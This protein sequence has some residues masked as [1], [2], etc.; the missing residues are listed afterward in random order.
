MAHQYVKGQPF[1]HHSC[2]QPRAQGIEPA[3]RPFGQSGDVVSVRGRDN[4]RLDIENPTCQY[5]PCR[6]WKYTMTMHN[7]RADTPEQSAQPSYH[8]CHSGQ[9]LVVELE[10][11]C[12]DVIELG[13]FARRLV[14]IGKVH[15]NITFRW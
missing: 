5:G 1:R 14:R 3:I 4:L 7:V 2:G 12:R 8:P 11:V 6:C 10:V 13:E 9:S 15:L